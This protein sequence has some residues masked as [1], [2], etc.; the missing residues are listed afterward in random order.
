MHVELLRD[1]D[2]ALEIL[3]QGFY[4]KVTLE[5]DELATVEKWLEL[6]YY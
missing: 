1:F 5:V 4:N 2:R 3:H 6:K